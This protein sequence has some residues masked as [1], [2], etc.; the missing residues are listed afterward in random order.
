MWRASLLGKQPRSSS[1]PT[2]PV[3]GG[4]WNRPHS[5]RIGAETDRVAAPEPRKWR[6]QGVITAEN[7]HSTA[8]KPAGMGGSKGRMPSALTMGYSR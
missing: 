5:I 6:C 1:N 7:G 3:G 8:A 4:A 2:S